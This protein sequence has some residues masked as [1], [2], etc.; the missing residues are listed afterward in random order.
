[1]FKLCTVSVALIGLISLGGC[2]PSN[3][4]VPVV[5]VVQPEPTPNQALDVSRSTYYPT[6]SQSA[7]V[8]SP[9]T[10]LVNGYAATSDDVNIIALANPEQDIF[11]NGS[12]TFLWI[13]D[14]TGVRYRRF[15]EHG[16]RRQEIWARHL[17]LTGLLN[18]R[19]GDLAESRRQLR[20]TNQARFQAESLAGLRQSGLVPVMAT[21]APVVPPLMAVPVQHNGAIALAPARPMPAI[22]QTEVLVPSRTSL[23]SGAVSRPIIER[24]RE[25]HPEPR[26]R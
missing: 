24:E 15:F 8:A 5:V 25:G 18:Q 6:Q 14:G 16:D 11:F 1:M 4:T 3:P 23:P 9:P 19:S 13:V 20:A 12:D 17:Q 22:H 7:Y 21:P 2:T 26:G 10:Y